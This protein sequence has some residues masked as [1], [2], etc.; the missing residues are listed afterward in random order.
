MNR[1]FLGYRT[2]D[3]KE[4]WVKPIRFLCMLVPSKRFC[5][6][7]FNCD[8]VKICRPSQPKRNSIFGW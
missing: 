3:G 8:R 4:V 7:E 6:S 1:V 5:E 2:G